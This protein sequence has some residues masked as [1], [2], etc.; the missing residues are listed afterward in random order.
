MNPFDSLGE[1]DYNEYELNGYFKKLKKKVKKISKSPLKSAVKSIKGSAMDIIKVSEKI[2]PKPLRKITT[3]PAKV[4]VEKGSLKNAI[5]AAEKTLV[6]IHKFNRKLVPKPI[7]E[8]ENKIMNHPAT[9]LVAGVVGAAFGQ[10]WVGPAAAAAQQMLKLEQNSDEYNR[11]KK[12]LIKEM[13]G[14]GYTRE[15][16]KR[17]LAN[18]AT[19]NEAPPNQ[20]K[21]V[22]SP[23]AD[24]YTDDSD[25]QSMYSKMRQSGMTPDQINKVWKQSDAYKAVAIPEIMEAVMPKV[26]DSYVAEGVPP[27]IAK[28][29]AVITSAKIADKE[30]KKQSTEDT[31]K[32]L[33]IAA[34]IFSA[35]IL[36]G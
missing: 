9:P 24:N 27:E 14:M 4:M 34:P 13:S 31:L 7:K 11:Q 6:D 18:P 21:I 23:N 16:I 20:D 3:E 1:I 33:A 35:L 19:F 29:Q 36:R 22:S 17:Y 8:I 5:K 28:P 10:A 26:Y 25:Y 12:I 30:V 2:T 32:Y 15:Q